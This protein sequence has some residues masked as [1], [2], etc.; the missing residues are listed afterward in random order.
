MSVGVT[1]IKYF[2]SIFSVFATYWA[3]K[4]NNGKFSDEDRIG[5]AARVF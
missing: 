1:F 2:V 5:G 3:L 4:T